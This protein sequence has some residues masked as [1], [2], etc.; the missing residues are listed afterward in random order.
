MSGFLTALNATWSVLSGT[1]Q[2]NPPLS[3][4]RLSSTDSIRRILAPPGGGS[5]VLL[6]GSSGTHLRASLVIS[7]QE[8]ILNFG[9]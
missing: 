7:V 3:D 2:K 8:K 9:D 5:A 6:P 1:E 4:R